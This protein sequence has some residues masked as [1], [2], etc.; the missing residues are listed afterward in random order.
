MNRNGEFL[1]VNAAGQVG[2]DDDTPLKEDAVF[3]LA[4]CT[5]ARQ[6]WLAAGR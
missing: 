2:K 6:L 5:K 3:W 4:S 1:T